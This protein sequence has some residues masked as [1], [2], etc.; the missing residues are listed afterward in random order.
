MPGCAA[1][2]SWRTL[3]VAQWAVV[4]CSGPQVD[5]QTHVDFVDG[6]RGI[7][8]LYVVLGHVYA[9]TRQW[10]EPELPE[11]GHESILKFVDQG[12]SAVAVFIVISGFCLMMPL[13]REELGT[14]SGGTGRFLQ[15][16][17]RRILPPYYA[18]L[19]LSI[20][21]MAVVGLHPVEPGP[22][23]ASRSGS[24][25][26]RP[27]PRPCDDVHDQRPALERRAR[28]PDLRPV[29]L[30]AAPRVSALRLPV[31]RRH[32]FALGLDP[33]RP[34]AV[35]DRPRLDLSLVPGLFGLGCLASHIVFSPRRACARARGWRHWSLASS[36]SIVAVVVVVAFVLGPAL[37]SCGSSTPWS[38]SRPPS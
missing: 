3:P 9:Y 26:H 35:G 1:C 38:A 27:Q 19:V 4:W 2:G 17:A 15:R 13:S 10:A 28:V 36:V 32:G 34:A 31:A 37:S 14:P 8:A 33:V 20:L 11:A 22:D 21:L 16:R 29:R 30:G 6:L 18:A 24:T 23:R 5:K 12:H 25:P 7:A